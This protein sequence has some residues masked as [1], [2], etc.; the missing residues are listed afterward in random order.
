MNTPDWK[1][2]E[3]LWQSSEAAA[4]ARDI[5]A[6]QNR[7]RWLSRL[8]LVSEIVIAIAGIGISAWVMTLDRPYALVMGG[9][10][11][12]FTLFAGAASLWARLP[13]RAAPD[14]S[15]AAAIETAIQRARASVR[16]GLASFWVVVAALAYFAVM[17]FIWATAPE[18]PPGVAQRMLIVLG[19]WS[20]WTGAG[21]AF[22]IVY[23]VRRAR[24]LARLEEIK[25]SL[26][27]E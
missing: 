9:G 25:R 16:W 22:A 23:Y 7:R 4:P 18:Y 13:R 1:E 11:L 20:A 8:V 3:R 12:L 27:A 19:A 17:A 2:L 14:D 5:I 24:E 21:Q 26:A 10:T 6:K 15:V